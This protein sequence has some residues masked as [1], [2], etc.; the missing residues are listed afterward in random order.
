MYVVV[1]VV[2]APDTAMY[3]SI[4]HHLIAVLTLI[5]VLFLQN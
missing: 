2:T 4:S 3:E 1:C 5:A